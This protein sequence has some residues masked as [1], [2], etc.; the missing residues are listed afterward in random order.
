MTRQQKKAKHSGAK[1]VLRLPDLEQSR[2][3]V[4]IYWLRRVLRN[5]M[6]MQLT[7]SLGGTVQNLVLHSIER[8]F[9]AIASFSNRSLLH[10][11]PSTCD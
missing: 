9:C 6:D 2:S 10:P 11:R 1:T 8:S 3:A 4:L 7:S 5:R